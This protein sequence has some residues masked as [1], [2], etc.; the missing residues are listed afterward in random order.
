M[1]HIISGPPNPIFDFTDIR[2]LFRWGI[3]VDGSDTIM[4]KQKLSFMRMIRLEGFAGFTYR[5]SS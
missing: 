1:F 4:E 2:R 3:V 5:V